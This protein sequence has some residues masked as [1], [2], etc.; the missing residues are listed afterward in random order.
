MKHDV[1]E[2]AWDA[3]NAA[4]KHIQ[5]ELG[6]KTGD[7]AG[8]FFSGPNGDDVL[9]IFEEYA[10]AEI[11]EETFED[12]E[13]LFHR[14]SKTYPA[15]EFRWDSDG[16]IYLVTQDMAIFDPTLSSCGRFDSEDLYGLSRED[17]E[18]LRDHNLNI[19]PNL[20]EA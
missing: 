1:K 18:A 16:I 5:D 9:R 17:A 19:N 13:A 8:M 4:C 3:L 6:I 12:A 2:L 10:E 7:V 20:P 11:R 14:L 15:H